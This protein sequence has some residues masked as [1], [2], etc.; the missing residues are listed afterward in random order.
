M[1]ELLL[2]HGARRV[3]LVAKDKE[4]Y[5]RELLDRKESVQLRLGL[6]ETFEVGTVNQED[7][8][9]YFG[10]VIAPEPTCCEYGME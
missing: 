6:C 1:S 10:E 4:R 7:D 9:V 3:D 5:L 2:A 8:T